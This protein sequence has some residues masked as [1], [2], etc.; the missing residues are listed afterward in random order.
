MKYKLTDETK[1]LGEVILHRIE[2]VTSFDDVKA[3]DKGG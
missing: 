3:G 1:N 2:C